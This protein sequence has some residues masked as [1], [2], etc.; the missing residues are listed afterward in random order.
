MKR[1]KIPKWLQPYLWSVGT[2]QLDLSK[3]KAYI[4]NKVLAYGKMCDIKWLFKIYSKK[5][6]KKVFIYKPLK[7]YSPW[8][9][10]FTKEILLEI[11]EENLN[12]GSYV[13][14]IFCHMNR[15]QI[16]EF[17]RKKQCCI[18]RISH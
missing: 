14:D 3:D 11:K 6:I 10:N 15:L 17:F 9:F 8:A 5:T 16:T 12:T 13:D 2:D 18:Q 4:I 7:I 1:N